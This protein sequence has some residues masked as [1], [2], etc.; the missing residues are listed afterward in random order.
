MD[1]TFEDVK[2][3]GITKAF[4]I[5]AKELLE[6]YVVE[7]LPKV[8]GLERYGADNFLSIRM[9]FVY[10]TKNNANKGLN[11]LLKENGWKVSRRE[12]TDYQENNTYFKFHAVKY[13]YIPDE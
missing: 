6:G 9:V 13:I 8:S 11:K 12:Y 2:N 4:V 1:M 3:H 10:P 7:S 5:E